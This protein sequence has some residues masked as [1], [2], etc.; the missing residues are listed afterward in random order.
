[1]HDGTGAFFILCMAISMA[2]AGIVF[3]ITKAFLFCLVVW[4]VTFF[5]AIGIVGWLM[6]RINGKSVFDKDER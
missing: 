5:S 6:N 1:M 2:V 3:F 4:V